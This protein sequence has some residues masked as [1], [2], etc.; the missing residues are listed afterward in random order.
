MV[1]LTKSSILFHKIIL[2][3][4]IY[5]M[6]GITAP[7]YKRIFNPENIRNIQIKTKIAMLSQT[8]RDQRG[9][10]VQRTSRFDYF[11]ICNNGLNFI[12]DI[13][14]LIRNTPGIAIFSAT[15]HKSDNVADFIYRI[16][17]GEPDSGNYLFDRTRYLLKGKTEVVMILIHNTKPEEKFFKETKFRHIQCEKIRFLK[18]FIRNLYNPKIN[19]NGTGEHI[20][21]ASSCEENVEHVLKMLNLKSLEFYKKQNVGV[22]KKF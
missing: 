12:D 10:L 1:F 16:Y 21:Y 5:I 6:K 2:K 3:I 18:E 4:Q 19:G 13:I 8:S 15:K 20:I 14:A 22:E 11:I 9:K 7:F 17:P